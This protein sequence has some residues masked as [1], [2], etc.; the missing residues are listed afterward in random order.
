MRIAVLIPSRGLVHSRT[1]QSILREIRHKKFTYGIFFTND[2]PI[3][4]SHNALT[5]KALDW[6]A[7]YLWF[8]EEDILVPRHTLEKMIALHKP[9]VAVDYPVG[10]KRYSCIAKKQGKI[11]WCGLGCTLID[12]GVFDKIGYPWFETNKTARITSEDPFEY[13]LEDIPNK[14]GGHD[15]LFGIKAREKGVEIAQLEGVTAGH[16]KPILM[17]DGR[18]NSGAHKF[19]VWKTI[20]NFQN[21]N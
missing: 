21:Y 19:E 13:K 12:R 10:E 9:I 3:P 15:I 7:D 1:M 16:I 11:L 8:V 4:E 14:Y 6:L 2:L 17:G 5:R 20:E 18:T